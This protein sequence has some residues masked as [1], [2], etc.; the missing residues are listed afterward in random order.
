MP[1]NTVQP[2]SHGN[3]KTQLFGKIAPQLQCRY[4]N[5]FV[6]RAKADC[7]RCS[8]HGLHPVLAASSCIMANTIS[9][10]T[11]LQKLAQHTH[12]PQKSLQLTKQPKFHKAAV[13]KGTPGVL[14]HRFR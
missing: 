12:T 10:L 5:C 7:V 9:A 13:I 2:E 1:A 4:T 11:Y 8:N 14:S 6:Y 3:H